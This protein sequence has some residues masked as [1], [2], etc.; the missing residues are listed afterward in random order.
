MFTENRRRRRQVKLIC[1]CREVR[2]DRNRNNEFRCQC[3]ENNRNILDILS[4]MGRDD[5]FDILSN[6]DRDDRNRIHH[7]NDEF[8]CLCRENNRRDFNFFE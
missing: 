3:R 8:R 4:N 2:F 6:M 1:E 5:H 7:Q